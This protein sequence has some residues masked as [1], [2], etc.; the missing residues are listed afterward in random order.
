MNKE[1]GDKEKALLEKEK[2]IEVI[3]SLLTNACTT[4]NTKYLKSHS[5]VALFFKDHIFE[6]DGEEEK[7]IRY[8]SLKIPIT[9]KEYKELLALFMNEAQRRA[10]DTSLK[11]LDELQH[12]IGSRA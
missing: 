8:M 11:K 1:N 7:F 9:S 12:L 6:I 4:L 3:K 10:Q 2:A 5:K